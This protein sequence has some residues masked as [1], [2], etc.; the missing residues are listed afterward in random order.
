MGSRYLKIGIVKEKIN[1]RPSNKAK[2]FPLP[3]YNTASRQA[4]Q[5]VSTSHANV[6]W[7]V[8]THTHFPGVV[9]WQLRTSWAQ[10]HCCTRGNRAERPGGACVGLISCPFTRAAWSQ[11]V[12]GEWSSEDFL[13]SF[14][15]L[16]L[17]G[18][19]RGNLSLWL[20][21]RFICLSW[22]M[23]NSASQHRN[24]LLTRSPYFVIVVT[25]GNFYE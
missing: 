13:I 20:G 21:G 4:T 2:R 9:L 11:N 15:T 3:D 24:S 12:G 5:P 16:V 25:D 10:L 8:P 1:Y 17:E 6:V 18:F 19:L 14:S 7:G 23:S 22:S